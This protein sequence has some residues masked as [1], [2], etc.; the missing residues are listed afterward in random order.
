[1]S[2]EQ[3][4]INETEQIAEALRSVAHKKMLSPEFV[5][6]AAVIKADMALEKLLQSE[7]VLEG[8]AK[9]IQNNT[10][11]IA[12]ALEGGSVQITQKP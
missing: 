7:K 4:A 11:R 1:M 12:A 2:N 8:I 9:D 6:A 5:V 3:I 10:D